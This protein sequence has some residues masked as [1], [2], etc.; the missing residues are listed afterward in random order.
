MG[1]LMSIAL[2]FSGCY[3]L[4]SSSID[5][6]LKT[7][8]VGNFKLIAS[9]APATL[10]QTLAES[11]K[12]KISRESRLKYNDENPD[13][14]FNGSIQGYSVSSIAPLPDERTSFNRLTINVTVDYTNNLDPKDKWTKSF[15]HF[16]DFP[17]EQNLTAVQDDLITIIF[18]QIL[19]DIFNQAFNNW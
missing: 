14:E 18:N 8:Y 17:A 7:Y 16:E 9:N 13:I 11:L 10:P 4:K 19:E 5:L 3:S 15:S 1:V 2:I 6:N 12:D